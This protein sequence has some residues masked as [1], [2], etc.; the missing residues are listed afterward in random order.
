TS[1]IRDAKDL[2]CIKTMG[3]R[4]EALASIAAVAQ[5]EMRT[6]QHI[7]DLGTRIVIEGSAVKTQE[8]CQ[9]P[10][11]TTFFIKNLFYNI[12]ARRNFLK[13]DSVEMRHILDEFQRIAIANPEVHFTLHHNNNE[14][15]H[16][17]SGNL[18]QRLVSIFGAQS[19]KKLVPVSEETD[20]VR[21]NGFVG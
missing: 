17:P 19:N 20:V 11:G 2:F 18:R 6:R 15:F 14:L 10:S 12:P 16:L 1:K 13:S 9:A 4:G 7:H 5:V 21:I 3:F 8:P